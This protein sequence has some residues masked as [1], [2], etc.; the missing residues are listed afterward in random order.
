ML[1]VGEGWVREAWRSK[2][3]QGHIGSYPQS[4]SEVKGGK[5]EFGQDQ[6][7]NALAAPQT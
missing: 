4:L 2:G 7:P 5:A 6:A 3:R 1:S